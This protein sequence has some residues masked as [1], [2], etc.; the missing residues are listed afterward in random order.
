MIGAA[1]RF[2]QLPGVS[3]RAVSGMSR[4]E[5]QVEVFE[6]RAILA[7][8]TAQ[9]VTQQA[10]PSRMFPIQGIHYIDDH[11]V[12]NELQMLHGGPS[13]R[14]FEITVAAPTQ[15]AAKAETAEQAARPDGCWGI[16]A[17]TALKTV[18]LR[19]DTSDQTLAYYGAVN[20]H[21]ATA[22]ESIS[23]HEAIAGAVARGWCTPENASKVMDSDLALAIVAEV[24]A[25]LASRGRAQGGITSNKSGS[26]LAP[27]TSTVSA[28]NVLEQAA[29]LC[30]AADKNTH[31]AELADAI[32]ALKVEG[33]QAAP[34][35][36]RN[37]ALEQ[38]ARRVEAD[39]LGFADDDKSLIAIARDIRALKRTSTDQADTDTGSA[40]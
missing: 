9:E 35:E 23:R 16:S 20:A 27:T 24:E 21:N 30:E 33:A 29:K 18:T 10:A 8:H 13:A 17:D 15:Q 40:A 11:G 2:D 26:D 4:A 14:G 1:P 28:P 38:A 37:Q 36:V 32:R 5:L 22:K 31:P 25:E 6:L 34:E 19:F 7:N 39:C 12:R 3:K